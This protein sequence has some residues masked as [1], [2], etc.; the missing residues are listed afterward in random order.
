VVTAPTT[1]ANPPG[2]GATPTAPPTTPKQ[3]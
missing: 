3:S 1:G 2:V